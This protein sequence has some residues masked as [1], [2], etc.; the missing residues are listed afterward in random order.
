MPLFFEEPWALVALIAL[1]LPLIVLLRRRHRR[2]VV[3]SVV[4]HKLAVQDTISVPRK[5]PWS[6]LILETG[7]LFAVVGA[8]A[9]PTWRLEQGRTTV[10]VV[11]NSMSGDA[12]SASGRV[13]ATVPDAPAAMH[14][15]VPGDIASAIFRAAM[16]RGNAGVEVETR[17]KAPDAR[18]TWLMW[19][20]FWISTEHVGFERMWIQGDSFSAGLRY[21]EN[22]Q[23]EVSISQKVDGVEIAHKAVQLSQGYIGVDFPEVPRDVNRDLVL[24]MVLSLFETAPESNTVH[25]VLRKKNTFRVEGKGDGVIL[26]AL[27]AMGW[28]EA[29][30]DFVVTR[31]KKPADATGIYLLNEGEETVG[32]RVAFGEGF[33]ESG[34]ASLG[35]P[36]NMIALPVPQSAP[37]VPFLY[38]EGKPIAAA[39][40]AGHRIVLGFAP[41]ETEWRDSP[42]WPVVLGMMLEAAG[43]PLN[44]ISWHVTGDLAITD[45]DG[46]MKVKAGE[47][48]LLAG[49]YKDVSGRLEAYNALWPEELAVAAGETPPVVLPP[50]PES[51]TGEQN[52]K[53]VDTIAAVIGV[54]LLA[55]GA[56]LWAR[57][58]TE[59]V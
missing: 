25:A 54:M 20:R 23:M 29:A 55:A 40:P 57:R 18:V 46:P 6:I 44:G 28:T 7:G 21:F 19:N 49:V 58:E 2:V 15:H 27:R 8:M 26:T 3:P 34:I 30:G 32:G 4:V 42:S 56:V 43:Y 12:F 47:R 51:G 53:P 31:V 16:I 17:R 11:D 52:V 1:F 48:V 33:D 39:D 50:L 22:R 36:A 37:W 59:Q 14:T 45:L 13:I 38:V 9:M 24:E 10:M 35:V 41:A 5:I